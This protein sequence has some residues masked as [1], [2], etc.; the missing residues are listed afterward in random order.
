MKAKQP[1]KTLKQETSLSNKERNVEKQ[2]QTCP[3]CK[4][5]W[6]ESNR[7]D[8]LQNIQSMRV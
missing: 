7:L 6:K 3:V 2:E 5:A 1:V 4:G 8:S